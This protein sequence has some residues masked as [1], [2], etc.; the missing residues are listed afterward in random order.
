M[1]AARLRPTL[2]AVHVPAIP[3]AR[4]DAK[5]IGRSANANVVIDDPSL[6]RLHARVTMSVDGEV[7][8]EDLGST[9]GLFV[10]GAQHKTSRLAPGD[11]LRLGLLEYSLEED[12]ASRIGQTIAQ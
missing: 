4:G 1:I 9:N 7:S 8:V 12:V 2:E 10:N 5:T 6:S 3:L 11:R